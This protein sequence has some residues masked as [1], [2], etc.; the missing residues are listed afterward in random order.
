MLRRIAR[1]WKDL[2]LPIA[3]IFY[4]VPWVGSQRAQSL[5]TNAVTDLV[6]SWRNAGH[7][8]PIL[9]HAKVRFK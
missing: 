5:V 6:A 2:P 4:D 3:V 7:W 8:L 9:R 1:L